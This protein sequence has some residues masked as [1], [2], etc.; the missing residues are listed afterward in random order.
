MLSLP[1]P[2]GDADAANQV[3]NQAPA[4]EQR[5]QQ[6][7]DSHQRDVEVKVLGKAGA[8]A[9][10]GLVAPRAS[11]GLV[12]PRRRRDGLLRR[13]AVIAVARS[14]QNLLVAVVANHRGSLCPGLREQPTKSSPSKHGYPKEIERGECL[15]PGGRSHRVGPW[16]SWSL[17]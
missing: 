8:D 3:G 7:N 4:T 1:C 9:G 5:H 10:D 12:R 2:Q 11:Q 17:L 15:V 16:V 13:A 6:P 14:V